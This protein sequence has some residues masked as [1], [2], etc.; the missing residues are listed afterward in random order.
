MAKRTARREGQPRPPAGDV[1]QGTSDERTQAAVMENDAQGQRQPD[2]DAIARRAY[3]IFCE[4][5][6][7]TGR[8]M[9]D[10]LR[11]ERELKLKSGG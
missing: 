10:W 1:R 7:E 5:G 11:A 3:E 6:C 8:D 2:P 4:R 9:D